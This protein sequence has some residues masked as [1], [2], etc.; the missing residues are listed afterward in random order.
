MEPFRVR[1]YQ[2]GDVRWIEIVGT[3]VRALAA[4][5]KREIG[6]AFEIDPVHETPPAVFVLDLSGVK[7]DALTLDV[8][9]DGIPPATR[10]ALIPPFEPGWYDA[11]R[12]RQHGLTVDVY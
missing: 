4:N 1:S 11:L 8:I 12:A 10:I 3:P 9:L 2:N 7:V 5:L 6:S